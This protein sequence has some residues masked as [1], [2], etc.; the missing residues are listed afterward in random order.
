MA[1]PNRPGRP[2]TRLGQPAVKAPAK[3]GP[4][5][6]PATGPVAKQ[7]APTARARSS[8]PPTRG[9]RAAEPRT[10]SRPAAPQAAKSNTPM[11]IGIVAGV[12]AILGIAAFAMSG[13]SSE[14]TT[15]VAPKEASKKKPVD[16]SGLERDGVSKCDAG[17]KMI[18]DNEGPMKSNSLSDAE[19]L[20]L[21][22]ELE[23]A[24][25]LLNE[26]MNLLSQANTKSDNKYDV[27]QYIESKK[28]ARMKLMEIGTSK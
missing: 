17:L 14:K 28:I 10:A 12:V 22:G 4:A 6:R 15:T 26:G 24:M 18:R 11:I 5:P 16:V 23:K 21:R 1:T 20:R 8:G 19:R 3:A 13:N 2:S 27:S 25:V 9:S 7:P